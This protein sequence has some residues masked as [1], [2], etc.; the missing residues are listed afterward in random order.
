MEVSAFCDACMF[1]CR[2]PITLIF[3]M[4]YLSNRIYIRLKSGRNP[5]RTGG[6]MA[7]NIFVGLQQHHKGRPATP[8]RHIHP[9][10]H[11][12]DADLRGLWSGSG[13]ERFGRDLMDLYAIWCVLTGEYSYLWLLARV[14]LCNL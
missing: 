7:D 5:R 12:F 13:P 10:E 14:G 3:D 8:S 11:L 2:H 6:V 1:F 4:V 9:D